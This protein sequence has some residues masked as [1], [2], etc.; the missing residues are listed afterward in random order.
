[1][2]NL[3]VGGD[4]HK[5]PRS[6]LDII[7]H[8]YLLLATD[9]I[10]VYDAR[11]RIRSGDARRAPLLYHRRDGRVR[12]LGGT[13]RWPPVVRIRE[14][15]SASRHSTGAR[16]SRRR[17]DRVVLALESE[18]SLS[19]SRPWRVTPG[20]ARGSQQNTVDGAGVTVRD[21]SSQQNRNGDRASGGDQ[22]STPRSN[23][24]KRSRHTDVSCIPVQ[25]PYPSGIFCNG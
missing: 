6:R 8:R 5:P 4:H 1:M 18:Q 22:S 12:L 15:A 9:R 11:E 2:Q 24:D 14:R 7:T 19:I 3:E 10:F 23:W 21:C 20:H 13:V 25:I 17:M 16:D